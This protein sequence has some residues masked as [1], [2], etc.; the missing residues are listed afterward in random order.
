MCSLADARSPTVASQAV[1][2]S[3]SAPWHDGTS[4]ILPLTFA[5]LQLLPAMQHREDRR[6]DR[7]DDRHHDAL[8]PVGKMA[9]VG[10][11]AAPG[12]APIAGLAVAHGVHEVGALMVETSCG[13]E[14]LSACMSMPTFFR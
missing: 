9:V 8:G 11:V 13:F 7:R 6:E 2:E 10:A 12:P 4:Q 5:L 3:D 1:D 14:L